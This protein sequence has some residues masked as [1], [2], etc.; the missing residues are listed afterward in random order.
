MDLQHLRESGIPSKEMMAMFKDVDINSDGTISLQ[1]FQI[2]YRDIWYV[3]GFVRF[4]LRCRFCACSRLRAALALTTSDARCA[5]C[6]LLCAGICQVRDA[7]QPTVVRAHA[8]FLLDCSSC[9]VN[10]ETGVLSYNYQT[11]PAL[12]PPIARRP[13]R[14]A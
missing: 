6:L 10:F 11:R 14:R 5:M 3:H 12:P 9:A 13:V 2:F 4:W 7:A 1:E 8:H